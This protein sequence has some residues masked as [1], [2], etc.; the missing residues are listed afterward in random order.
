ML[1]NS[2]FIAFCRALPYRTI[3]VRNELK[4]CKTTNL[5]AEYA[6]GLDSVYYSVF[7]ISNIKHNGFYINKI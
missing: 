2:T 3:K 7:I 6:L 1:A 4:K 5:I